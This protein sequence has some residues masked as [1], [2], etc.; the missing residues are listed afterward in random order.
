MSPARRRTGLMLV[1]AGTRAAGGPGYD[2]GQP[3]GDWDRG[4]SP[5]TKRMRKSR[6][7]AWC[8]V[9][10]LTERWTATMSTQPSLLRSWIDAATDESGIGH[11]NVIVILQ[12]HFTFHSAV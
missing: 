1:R 3:L 4:M 8:C 7:G 5:R 11:Q 12:R 6:A 9:Q 10:P 2:I